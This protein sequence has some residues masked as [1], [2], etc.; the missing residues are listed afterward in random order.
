M[1]CKNMTRHH[2][3]RLLDPIVIFKLLNSIHTV[4]VHCKKNIYMFMICK[5]NIFFFCQIN[6]NN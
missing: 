3:K 6:L 1:K 4:L 5:H 2:F